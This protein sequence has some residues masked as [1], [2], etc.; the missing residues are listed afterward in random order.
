[1]L[2]FGAADLVPQIMSGALA[3][4]QA[5]NT[6]RERKQA[7]KER[8]QKVARLRKSGADLYDLVAED[9]MDPDEAIAALEA[10]E[11][12]AR[13]EREAAERKLAPRP[14]NENKPNSGRRKRISRNA[15]TRPSFSARSWWPWRGLTGLMRQRNTTQPKCWPDARSP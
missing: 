12:K 2:D 8:E 14:A 11:E 13:I 7:I 1:M 4:Q 3:L 15:G 10:R 6:A 9:R 5:A